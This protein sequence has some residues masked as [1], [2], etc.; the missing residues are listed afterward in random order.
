MLSRV[1]AIVR[2]NRTAS[3]TISTIAF[4]TKAYRRLLLLHM[5]ASFAEL[6]NRVNRVQPHNQPKPICLASPDTRYETQNTGGGSWLAVVAGPAV[7]DYDPTWPTIFERLRRPIASAVGQLALA[8]EH[9]GSTAV[10]GLAAKPIID[11]DVVARERSH[12]P[13]LIGLLTPLGY[14]HV[15]DLGI[16]GREAFR[17]PAALPPHHLYLV[18]A[19]TKPYSDHVLFREYLRNH[20]DA[21]AR[22]AR[23]KTRAGRPASG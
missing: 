5:R 17:S 12:V 19:G 10:P 16:A 9:V 11:M 18:V 4:A 8:V 20:P 14:T 13:E 7:V 3:W 1:Y 2:M 23:R 6:G 22:Y 15:G 21:V